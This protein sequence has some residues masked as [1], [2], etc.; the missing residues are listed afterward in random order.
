[1][2]AKDPNLSITAHCPSMEGVNK[3][4]KTQLPMHCDKKKKKKFNHNYYFFD[5]G[6]SCILLHANFSASKDGV[7]FFWKPAGSRTAG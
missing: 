3:A 4:M 5:Q 6:T 1:M 7:Y 2:G